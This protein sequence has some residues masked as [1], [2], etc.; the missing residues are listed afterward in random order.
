M[1]TELLDVDEAARR[2]KRGGVLVYPTE[3]VFGLGCDPT[4]ESAVRRLLAIKQRDVGKGLILIA[5]N[6]EQVA[7]WIRRE[8]VPQDV[9]LRVQESWPGPN[10]WLL[11]ASAAVPAWVRG[12]HPAVALRVTAHPVAAAL[13][14]AFGGAL[15]S[16]SANASGQPAP[17]CPDELD[18][19]LLERCDGRV[20]GDC[21][22][23]AAPSS[24]RDALSGEVL[25]G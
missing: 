24:I 3:A 25:R 8:R 21:G 15:V 11:P 18:R 22:G 19:S 9:W 12:V 13:C 4:N 10:T 1:D 2:L 20:G 23:A 6:L 16:T 5:A 17:H 14:S 7:R